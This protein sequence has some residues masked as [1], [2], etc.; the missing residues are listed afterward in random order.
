VK[1]AREKSG[2]IEWR[3]GTKTEKGEREFDKNSKT[4]C[5]HFPFFLYCSY[6]AI[7]D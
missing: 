3:K 5:L 2:P 7:E 6:V 4:F 1:S